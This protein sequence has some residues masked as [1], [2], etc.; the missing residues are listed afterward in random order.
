M[1]T[2]DGTNKIVADNLNKE[3]TTLLTPK[4]WII[5]GGFDVW[6][7]GTSQTA[8]GYGS[9]DRWINEHYISTKTHSRQ[10]FTL[11]QTEVPNNPTYFSRTVANAIAGAYSK[12][13]KNQ[14]IEDVTKLA[15][16]TVSLSFWAKA[17]ANK[18]ISVS[19]RQLFGTGGSTVVSGIGATK[20][21]LTT[22]WQRVTLTTLIPSVSGKTIGANNALQ[23]RIWFSGSAETATEDVSLGNQSGTFDIANVS[24]VE[25]SVPVEWQTESYADVL[26]QC[27]RYGYTPFG[28]ET[29]SLFAHIGLGFAQ[30]STSSVIN[31]ELPKNFRA[32]PTSISYSGNLALNWIDNAVT[33]TSIAIESGRTSNKILSVVVGVAGGLTAY[34]PL[35]LMRFNTSI[36]TFF[37]DCEL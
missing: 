15:G 23:L 32:I 4:N 8:D 5:N 10:A 1:L 25:G 20:F 19:F 34:R 12:V 6:Q 27:Q 29:T 9:D 2:L 22:S 31:I 18:Y 7:R 13:V 28:L 14:S 24:L 35:F 33:A 17:D 16:K 36:A 30:N 37:V 3:V 26:R 21:S 11:G